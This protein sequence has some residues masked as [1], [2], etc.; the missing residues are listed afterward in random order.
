VDEFLTKGDNEFDTSMLQI[1]HV[2]LTR[3]QVREYNPPPN[4]AKK[5][6][7]R[8]KKYMVVHGIHSWE[9]D[10]LP[11][12]VLIKL[13]EDAIRQFIDMKKYNAVIARENELKKKLQ[14]FAD[15]LVADE[16]DDD[17]E[18]GAND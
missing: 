3:D 6:D 8:S 10:A 2:G 7:P 4:P 13:V 16:S 15:I 12:N 17:E 9:L 14:E 11:P 1:I 5:T 18:E